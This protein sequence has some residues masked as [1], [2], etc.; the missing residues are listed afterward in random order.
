VIPVAQSRGIR[1]RRRDGLPLRS[2]CMP[3]RGQCGFTLIEMI[4]VIIVS[5]ALSM[6]VTQFITAP[7]D[8]YVDQSRRARLVDIAQGATD[9]IAR[10]VQQALPNSIRVGCAGACVELLHVVTGGRYR[11]GPPGDELSFLPVDA[12]TDFDV[13]GPFSAYADLATSA[14]ASACIDGTAACVSIYNTGQPGT[15][16]WNSDHIGGAWRPDNLATLSAVTATSVAFINTDFASGAP[17]FPAASP[18][19]RFYI[20][21]TPVSYLCD[22]AAGT[23][24][25]Y[26][27]Y[28]LTHPHSAADEHAE[29]VALSNPAEFSLVADRVSA[30]SFAYT[31]GTPTRNGVLRLRVAIAEAGEGVTLFEQVHVP[32]M[33]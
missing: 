30:C 32:N 19:R 33:P 16:A 2:P 15:D 11:A 1:P 22:P 17:V 27:G 6:V 12:D 26:V 29:L 21:D 4:I 14:S 23:L 31:A 18:D 24:R 20:V 3:S 10:D 28:S 5:G 13:L 25:R 7:V 9:R 8:A